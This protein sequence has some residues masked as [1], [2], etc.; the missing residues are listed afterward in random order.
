MCVGN[1]QALGCCQAHRHLASAGF[2]ASSVEKY[3][4]PVYESSPYQWQT[5]ICSWDY[6]LAAFAA[7]WRTLCMARRTGMYLLVWIFSFQGSV[8]KHRLSRGPF[9]DS[10]TNQ[11]E[12]NGQNKIF[13]KKGKKI[14]RPHTMETGLR[15]THYLFNPCRVRVMR[16]M[17]SR[18][19]S[20]TPLPAS[21]RLSSSRTRASCSFKAL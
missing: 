12:I 14:S 13:L 16:L 3:H 19:S 4:C 8:S 7:S 2:S 6:R 5:G 18:S 11:Q 20:S 1:Q 9:T 10:E 17:F 15:G 21:I